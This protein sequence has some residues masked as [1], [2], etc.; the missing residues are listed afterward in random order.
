MPARPATPRRPPPN[1]ARLGEARIAYET[2]GSGTPVV[3]VHGWAG[4][5]RMWKA[6]EERLSPQA[7]VIALDLIGHGQSDAPEGK[8]TMARLAESITAVLD[9]VGVDRAVIVGYSQ[10]VPVAREFWRLHPARTLGIAAID[11]YLHAVPLNPWQ[12]Q[13][14]EL[15]RGPAWSDVVE[16]MASGM[17]SIPAKGVRSR[18]RCRS[19]RVGRRDPL[20]ALRAS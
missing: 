19:S 7:R 10:G 1:Y 20:H 3:L 16:K 6:Q 2:S 9:D 18:A 8:Y 15:L 17:S 14:L 12:T 5:R 4:D 13:M 11:G